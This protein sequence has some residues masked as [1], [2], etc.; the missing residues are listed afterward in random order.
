[1]E[2][3]IPIPQEKNT[4][5]SRLREACRR[6]QELPLH[7]PVTAAEWDNA[8][9]DL[10]GDDLEHLKKL[11]AGYRDRAL[12]SSGVSPAEQ[13]EEARSAILLWPHDTGWFRSTAEEFRRA[14]WQGP[15]AK[16]FFEAL[17][18]R[19]GRR[20]GPQPPRGL[21]PLLL[22]LLLISSG[23]GLAVVFGPEF[24]KGKGVSPIQGPRDL[25]AVFDTQGVKTNI[26]VAGSRLLLFP[27]ATVAEISAWVT[28]PDHRIDLWEGTVTVLDASGEPLTKREV[29][30]HGSAEAPLE[31]GQGVEVFEQFNAHPFF[32]RVSGFQVATT[33]IL[34]QEARPR[35]R[36]ELSVAGL[37]ALT[38]GYQ[39]RVWI[40][41][42]QW[43]DR[44]A[45]RVHTLSLELENSG[46][47]PFAELQF[48]LLW[49][50]S[51][52]KTL[53]TISLRPVSAFR[54]ALPPGGKFPWTQESVF[55]TEVFSWS[56]G[57]EPHLSLE[58]TRW[59]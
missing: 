16:A 53:K 26:Q 5:A 12:E 27:D 2:K 28:F 19:A 21:L 25:Q 6:L 56:P 13:I 45:S 29:T 30:F 43:T 7:R 11:A 35:D 42:D 20:S 18:K 51:S 54:T 38:A 44:F 57:Q 46:L 41:Q 15:E 3:E 23:I 31:P 58:L 50:D 9:G 55:D 40:L 32:D 14:G 39:L 33:R 37:T 1:M 49:R 48:R 8:T 22:T 34:A 59:Q 24:G 52:G 4:K 36:R 17:S 10:T 47:K